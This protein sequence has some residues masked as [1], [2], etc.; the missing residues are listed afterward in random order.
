MNQWDYLSFHDLD[1]IVIPMDFYTLPEMI[2]HLEKSKKFTS[3]VMPQQ[4]FL[5]YK[6]A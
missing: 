4:L 5:P 6:Q 2:E 3:M 1:E